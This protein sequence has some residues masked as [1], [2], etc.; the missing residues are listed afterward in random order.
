ML[1]RP[2]EDCEAIDVAVGCYMRY[3]SAVEDIPS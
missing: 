3:L 1:Y 2:L